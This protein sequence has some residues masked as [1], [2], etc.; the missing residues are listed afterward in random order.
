MAYNQALADNLRKTLI[1]ISGIKEQKKMGGVSFMLHK[2]LLIRAHS[3]NNMLLRCEPKRTDELLK[4][5]GAKRFEM[6]NKPSMNG[7]LLI[8]PE[9]L[10]NKKDLDYWIDIALEY[11]TKLPTSSKK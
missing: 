1:H 6:K 2:K 11:N 7:W 4:Q 8:T 9:G 3:D 5:K 10:E